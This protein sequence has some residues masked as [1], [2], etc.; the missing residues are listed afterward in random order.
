MQAPQK[1]HQPLIVLDF[2]SQVTQ[3][4]ARRIREL[5]V[6]A[7]ILPFHTSIEVIRSRNPVAVILSGGPASIGIEGAPKLN[8]AVLDLGVPVLG[9]CYGLYAIV[10]ALG[11]SISAAREREFGAATLTVDAARGP[12][13]A[14]TPGVPEPVWMSHGDQVDR[15]PPGFETV[16]HTKT[17]VHA[18]IVDRTRHFWGVQFHP[19]VTHTR[20]GSE[21]IAAF[22]DAAGFTR[23]W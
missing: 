20:R 17:C 13:T 14:F 11:G 18:A 15:L 23:D 1:P 2:G 4:I 16:A 19:E 12:M 8:P 6:Y 10:D 9:I 21:V 22:L 5:G 3:L 7:E